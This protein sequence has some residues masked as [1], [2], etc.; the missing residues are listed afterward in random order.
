VK[1]L[2]FARG[3]RT[4]TPTEPRYDEVSLLGGEPLEGS[5]FETQDPEPGFQFDWPGSTVR[6]KGGDQ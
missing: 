1:T 5:G 4:D 6:S 3:V 2:T